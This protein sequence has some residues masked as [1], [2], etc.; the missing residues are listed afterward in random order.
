[1]AGMHSPL[2]VMGG[3]VM[4]TALAAAILNDSGNATI[5]SAAYEQ[6]HSYFEAQTGTTADTLYAYAH[7]ADTGSDRFADAVSNKT[8][9]GTRLTNG[10]A[11]INATTTAMTV[12]K[13]AEVLLETRFPYLSA[14]Q[15]RVVLRTTG[16]TSG[17]PLLDDAEGWGRLN[18]YAAA[19]GYGEFNGD[20]VVTMDASLGGFNASDRWRNDISGGGKLKKAGSGALLL[21]GAN[22]YSGGTELDAGTLEA[23]STTALG[24]GDVYVGGGTLRVDAPGKLELTGDYGQ[25]AGGTLE[26]VIG[27]DGQGRVAIDGTATVSGGTLRVRFADGYAPQN[28]DTLN[29][30][31]AGAFKGKFTTVEADGLSATPVYGSSGVQLRI[32]S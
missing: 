9:Y 25:I 21:A 14:D 20:V 23:A 19:D 1:M 13:G 30:I 18:L 12:P 29:L 26:L 27:A 10:F 6:A 22:Q 4:A 32:G 28:G 24:S 7:A 3:R 8:A 16:L 11:T 5:K 15:R 17:Y 31:T 2:D